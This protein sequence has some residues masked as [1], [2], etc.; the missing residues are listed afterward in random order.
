VVGQLERVS[1]KT[2]DEERKRIRRRSGNRKRD[3]FI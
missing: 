3:F 1:A 2:S